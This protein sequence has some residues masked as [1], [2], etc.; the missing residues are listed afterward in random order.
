[1]QRFSAWEIIVPA[2]S[3]YLL[4]LELGAEVASW[5]SPHRVDIR[6]DWIDVVLPEIQYRAAQ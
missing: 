5:G 6:T 2:N 1:M 3:D 4:Q